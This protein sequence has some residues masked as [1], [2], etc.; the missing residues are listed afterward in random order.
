MSDSDEDIAD[1][2]KHVAAMMAVED[3]DVPLEMM[4]KFIITK[5]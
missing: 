2:E 4:T 5:K 3:P 1:A